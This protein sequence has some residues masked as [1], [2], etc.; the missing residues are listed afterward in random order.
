MSGHRAT[1]HKGD[2]LC[3]SHSLPPHCSSLAVDCPDYYLLRRF[4]RARSYDLE[5]ATLMWSNFLAWREEHQVDNILQDFYF[6]EREEF[7]KVYPQGYHKLD[8]IVSG[9]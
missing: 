7:L 6:G 8:K 3:A 2:V 4:L 1:L 9:P 5:K